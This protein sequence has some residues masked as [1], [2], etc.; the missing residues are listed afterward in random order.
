MNKNE[1]YGLLLNPFTRIAG[2]QAFVLGV[3]FMLLIGIT[4]TYANVYFDGAIDVHFAE[5]ANLRTS[6]NYLVIDLLSLVLTLSVAGIFIAKNFRLLDILGTVSLAKAPF[7][8]LALVALAAE[9]PN[10]EQIMQDPSSIFSSIS[11]VIVM[12][13]SIPVFIWHII[14][15]YNAFRLSTGAKGNKVVPAFIIALLVAEIV[16]KILIAYLL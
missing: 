7:L 3:F 12:I 13:L 15:L 4:G 11:F 8:I 10:V 5:N 2:W 6:L 9:A 1:I 16:S 14:L